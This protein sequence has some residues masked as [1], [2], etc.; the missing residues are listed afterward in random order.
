M[1][2]L[3]QEGF[4]QADTGLVEEIC[5]QL[6]RLFFLCYKIF[7]ACWRRVAIRSRGGALQGIRKRDAGVALEGA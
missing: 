5:F 1:A 7:A 6:G 3:S 2:Y 4:G